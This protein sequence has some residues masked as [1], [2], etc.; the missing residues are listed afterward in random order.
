MG[1][2]GGAQ[3]IVRAQTREQL[4]AALDASS[5]DLVISD[6]SMPGFDALGALQVLR[7]RKLDLPFI[8]V[9][10]TIGEE[11]AVRALK[12]GASDFVAKGNLQR[13]GPSILRELREGRTRGEKRD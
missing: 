4:G 2:V 5:F 9:S 8:I 7:E 13:M 1:R 3:G 12:A 11:A 10:G 6:W